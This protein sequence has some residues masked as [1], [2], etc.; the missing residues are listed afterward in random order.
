M[1]VIESYTLMLLL[2]GICVHK[3]TSEKLPF[4]EVWRDQERKGERM[5]LIVIWFDF[6]EFLL[7][8]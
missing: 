4:T 8:V 7:R 5:L 3:F 2:C 1:K 6:L